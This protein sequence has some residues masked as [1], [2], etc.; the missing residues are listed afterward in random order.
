MSKST[1][2][3]ALTRFTFKSTDVRTIE[4]DGLIWFVAS[5]IAKALGYADAAQMTRNLDDDERGL[6]NVQTPSA[7]QQMVIINESGL[8]H[9]LLKSRK[10]E[11]QPFRKWVTAEVL[12]AIRK[13]G[14]Y[15]PE[16]APAQKALPKPPAISAELHSRINRRAWELSH[17]AYELYRRQMQ[18]DIMVE[19]GHTRPEDW[20]PVECRRH[21]LESIE[22]A[23]GTMTAFANSL[24]NDGHRLAGL[25]GLDFDEVAQKF[26]P[27]RKQ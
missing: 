27:E 10:P 2:A 3:S 9:A 15:K 1:G 25:V 16:A 6:H 22:V 5:D 12:P 20:Q 7:D 13:E 8:Y 24:R 26:R 19:K 11:A 23:A 21:V 4:K 14:S 17:A 18:E